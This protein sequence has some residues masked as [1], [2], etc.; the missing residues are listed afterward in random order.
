MGELTRG[1]TEVISAGVVP[2][3]VGVVV[4][5][6]VRW[7]F[8]AWYSRLPKRRQRAVLALVCAVR[9]PRRRDGRSV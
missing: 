7:A 1:L 3:G 9:R 2:A 8:I 6:A 4:S 5:F